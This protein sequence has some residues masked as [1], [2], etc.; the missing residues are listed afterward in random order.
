M[1]KRINKKLVIIISVVFIL[2]L[3]AWYVSTYWVQLMLIQGDSMKPT[4]KNHSLVL[5][6]KH[7]KDYKPGDVIVFKHDGIKGV[8][9]KRVVAT[10]GDTVCIKEGILYVNGNPSDNQ[11]TDCNIA[12]AGIAEKEIKIP[13]DSYFVLGDNY[14]ESKDSRYEE[15]GIVAGKDVIGKIIK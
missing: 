4:Y 2:L 15:I 10:E 6:D 11:R 7:N 5:V 12:Y 3:A 1:K 8:V 14:D 9:V 13:A